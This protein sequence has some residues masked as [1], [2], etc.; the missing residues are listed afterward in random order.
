MTTHHD[1]TKK[2]KKKEKRLSHLQDEE[3]DLHV[4]ATRGAGLPPPAASRVA[5]QLADPLRR[6]GQDYLRVLAQQDPMA[7]FFF[8]VPVTY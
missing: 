5:L 8:V 3:G 4:Q 7:L 1:I 6:R 2:K